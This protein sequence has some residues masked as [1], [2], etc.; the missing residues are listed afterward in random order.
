MDRKPG[1]LQSMGSQRVRHY[2]ATELNGTDSLRTVWGLRG[3]QGGETSGSLS[4]HAGSIN[5][6]CMAAP[7]SSTRQLGRQCPQTGEEVRMDEVKLA[8]GWRWEAGAHPTLGD[9]I[10]SYCISGL[11]TKLRRQQI[12]SQVLYSQA[13]P[14]ILY[15]S[16]HNPS[17]Q[18]K[19]WLSPFPFLP[20]HPQVKLSG[21][22]QDGLLQLQMSHLEGTAEQD[23]FALLFMRTSQLC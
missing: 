7:Q 3:A 14:S 19:T 12:K 18:E 9:I 22:F 23:F 15:G 21:L 10:L 13:P 2:R 11:W 20:D 16:Q 4:D 17:G 6:L 5:L 1:R 8:R